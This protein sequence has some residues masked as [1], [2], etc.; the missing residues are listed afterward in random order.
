MGNTKSTSKDNAGEV[1]NV[2]KI[3]DPSPSTQ[4]VEALLLIQTILVAVSLVY[5]VYKDH[6]RGWKKRYQNNATRLDYNQP[7]RP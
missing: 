1:N 3:N 4:L 5:Q 6:R 7:Q 2:V